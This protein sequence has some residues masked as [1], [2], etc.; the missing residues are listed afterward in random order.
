MNSKEIIESV[1][2]KDYTTLR[3][4]IDYGVNLNVPD[5]DGRT[6]LMHAVLAS[7]ADAKMVRFLVDNGANPNSLDR[8]QKWTALHLAA[9]DQKVPIVKALLDLG[10]VV[11]AEDSF[12]NTPL[13]RCVMEAKPR[14]EILKMLLENGANQ[15]K[16]NAHGASPRD[17]A[18]RMG[19]TEALSL[20]AG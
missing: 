15:N 2:R 3:E 13:W 19:K 10:S 18:E 9:R 8:A 4:A 1:Y 20:F 14:P 12:G 7:D 6:P 17:I 11:D 16:K 5:E